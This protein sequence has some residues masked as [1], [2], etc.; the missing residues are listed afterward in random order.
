[1]IVDVK[2]IKLD[3]VSDENSVINNMIKF[4][5]SFQRSF[6]LILVTDQREAMDKMLEIQLRYV[7]HLPYLLVIFKDEWSELCTNH[8]LQ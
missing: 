7:D 2:D 8:T 5:L 1:M 3:Q 6:I 4:G